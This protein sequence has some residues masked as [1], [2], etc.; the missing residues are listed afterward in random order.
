MWR[1]WRMWQDS[2][3]REYLVAGRVVLVMHLIAFQCLGGQA[4]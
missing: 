1:M 2:V 3:P 4:R